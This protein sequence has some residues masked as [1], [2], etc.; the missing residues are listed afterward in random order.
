MAAAGAV[1]IIATAIAYSFKL[2]REYFLSALEVER[3]EK[4]LSPAAA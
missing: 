1:G 4:L 2:N 3:G